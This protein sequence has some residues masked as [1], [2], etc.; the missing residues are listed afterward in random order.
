MY[1][2]YFTSVQGIKIAKEAKQKRAIAFSLPSPNKVLP[3]L[4]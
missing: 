1:S 2:R 3:Y 4:A